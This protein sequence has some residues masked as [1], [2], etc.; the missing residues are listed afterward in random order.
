MIFYFKSN[1]P[2]F[3][4]Y[5]VI[6]ATYPLGNLLANERI[7]PRGKRIFGIELNPGKFSV[8]EAILIR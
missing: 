4:S 1:A 2:S 7:I 5:F 8:K 6:L 3:S